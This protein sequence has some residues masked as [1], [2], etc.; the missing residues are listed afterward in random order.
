L[1]HSKYIDVKYI[2]ERIL[3]ELG[4][5]W[6]A[7]ID[8][9]R[10]TTVLI[11]EN[12]VS[13]PI[14][15][16][17]RFNNP[18][19]RIIAMPAYVGGKID[20]AGIKWIASFPGNIAKSI[21]RAHSI[22][23]LN[24]AETGAPTAIINSSLLSAIRTACVS[25]FVLKKYLEA[26][27]K[28]CLDVGIIGF[29]PIGRLH[30]ELIGKVFKDSVRA[31]HIFDLIQPEMSEIEKYDLDIKTSLCS[32][33]E[34]VFEKSDLLI[35]CTVAK[36]RY[37]NLTP[38]Q[39]RAYFN[40]SLRDYCPFFLKAVDVSVVDNWEEVCRE[41]TDIQRAADEFGLQ[42]KDV[43]E[44]TDILDPSK[45]TS[46]DEKS[47]MFNPMGMAV[48]DIAIAQYYNDLATRRKNLIFLED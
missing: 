17:L 16:Y 20:K 42:K 28:A 21:R 9:V 44:I 38:R 31:V 43:L 2:N 37:I 30:L 11:S 23:V 14:K 32:T 1:D 22:V 24:S 41:N 39:G 15:P 33:W 5:D 35:T 13:Q 12:K 48:Y 25:G 46:L 6:D 26:R 7:L 4:I 3:S 27:D 19:N 8:V 36:S 34:E 40:V 18:D 45:L 29:G 10:D 47:F